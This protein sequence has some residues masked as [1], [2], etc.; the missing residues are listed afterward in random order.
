MAVGTGFGQV[1]RGIG[2]DGFSSLL[3]GTPFETQFFIFYQVKW[4]ESLFHQPYSS[5]T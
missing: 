3:K 2:E 5:Q 1:F 4:V